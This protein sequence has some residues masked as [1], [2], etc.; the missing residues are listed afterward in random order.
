M[1]TNNQSIALRR[2]GTRNITVA[3]DEKTYHDIRLWCAVRDISVSRVVRTFLQDLPCLENVR[4]FPAPEAP[5][6]RSLAAQWDEPDSYDLELL[7]SHLARYT[8]G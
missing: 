3:V 7:L 1:T 4:R 6:Y 2:A 5:D 8:Q